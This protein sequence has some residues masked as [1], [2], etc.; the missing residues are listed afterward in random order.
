MHDT[1]L[2]LALVRLRWAWRLG[3]EFLPLALRATEAYV[4]RFFPTLRRYVSGLLSPV[5]AWSL[6]T[7]ERLLY[8]TPVCDSEFLC[9]ITHTTNTAA[10]FLER[11]KPTVPKQLQYRYQMSN[12]TIDTRNTLC[13]NCA[14]RC[15]RIAHHQ[16][17][18]W[19][20]RVARSSFMTR[21]W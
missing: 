1:A 12:A 21:R 16:V 11:T 7:S 6:H 14:R 13:L 5:I 17:R 8:L 3:E 20:A 15:K 4:L 9:V 10:G 19:C 2:A 18:I